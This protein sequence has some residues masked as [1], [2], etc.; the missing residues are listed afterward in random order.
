MS[1]YLENDLLCTFLMNR[2]TIKEGKE[3]HDLLYKNIDHKW[4]KL[5]LNLLCR[6]APNPFC[7]EA[8]LSTRRRIMKKSY[9]P[10]PHQEDLGGSRCVE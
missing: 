8:S 4:I 6:P 2:Q 5:N 10:H 9:N 7:M 3:A 1:A